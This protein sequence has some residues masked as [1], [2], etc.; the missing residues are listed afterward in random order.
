MWESIGPA[1]RAVVWWIAWSYA[2]VVVIWL[3]AA[4]VAQ[5]HEYK[6]ERQRAAWLREAAQRRSARP[7][8]P[9][10]RSP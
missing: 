4:L 2:A 7:S 5:Y 1:G 10:D 6:R 9:D 3:S 8:A